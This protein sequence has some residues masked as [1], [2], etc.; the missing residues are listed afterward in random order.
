M[1]HWRWLRRWRA[2]GAAGAVTVATAARAVAL[3]AGSGWWMDGDDD[4]DG[5][6]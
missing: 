5:L 1:L 4:G 6:L 3:P 2:A